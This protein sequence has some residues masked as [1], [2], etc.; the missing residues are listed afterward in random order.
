[1][2]PAWIVKSRNAVKGEIEKDYFMVVVIILILLNTVFLAVEYDG[3]PR[4]LTK[5]LEIA[6][7][8]FTIIF[9]MEMCV[10]LY[11]LGLK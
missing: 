8:F 9:A 10:K 1:V 7:T 5:Y 2:T 3:M 6:N 4:A 11:G